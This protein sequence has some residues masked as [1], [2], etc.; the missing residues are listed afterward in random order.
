VPSSLMRTVTNRLS[1]FWRGFSFDTTLTSSWHHDTKFWHREATVLG[2]LSLLIFYQALA[3]MK[4]E[5]LIIVRWTSSWNKGFRNFDSCRRLFYTIELPAEL[6]FRNLLWNSR[7]D[8]GTRNLCWHKWLNVL[9]WI[10]STTYWVE[11]YCL[12]VLYQELFVAT[13]SVHNPLTVSM[14]MIWHDAWM[15]RIGVRYQMSKGQKC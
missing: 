3:Y 10:P 15:H 14:M 11:Q 12:M 8:W 5:Q 2:L 9:C 13:E 7:F 4:S 1:S 6:V